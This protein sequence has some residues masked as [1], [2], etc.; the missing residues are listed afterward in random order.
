MPLLLVTGRG[1]SPPG[2]QQL[3]TGN[4]AARAN[5][6]YDNRTGLLHERCEI[7]KFTRSLSAIPA[8]LT[9]WRAPGHNPWHLAVNIDV[10]R[11]VLVDPSFALQFFQV[12]R[13]FPDA[14]T[15]ETSEMDI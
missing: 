14:W 4:Q 1:S 8:P 11:L 2:C 10:G 9:L 5:L 3:C 13:F 7:Y 12:W 6:Q 15:V